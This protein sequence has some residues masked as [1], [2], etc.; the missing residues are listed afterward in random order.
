MNEKNA[1]ILTN[2]ALTIKR[3]SAKISIEIKLASNQPDIHQLILA[4]Y[5]RRKNENRL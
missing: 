3:N 1:K 2:L 4:N 5:H